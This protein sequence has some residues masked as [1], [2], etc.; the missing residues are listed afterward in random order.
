MDPVSD[1]PNATLYSLGSIN[2]DLQLCVDALPGEREMLLATRY[3]RLPGG[4]AANVAWF[5][6]RLGHRPVLLGRVGD[7]DFTRQ[8]LEPLAQ[9]GVDLRGV[10]RAHGA[11]GVA[12]V[13][14]PPDGKKRIVAAGEANQGFGEDDIDDVVRRVSK[15]PEGSVLAADYEVTPACV[16]RAIA[17][18][19]AR[20][21]RVVV[22]PSFPERVPHEDM[23]LIDVITPNEKEAR[24]LAGLSDASGSDTAVALAA[25]HVIAECGVRTVCVKL[26]GGGCLVLHEGRCWEQH[27]APINIVDTTGAGDAFTSAMA[28]SLLE[29]RPIA[30]AARRA[31]AASECAVAGYG[32]QPS[33]PSAA[34]LER[35]LGLSRRSEPCDPQN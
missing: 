17:A 19:K 27:A 32:A 3:A 20:G 2:A 30:E 10:Q 18:A 8:A 13:L 11:T 28:L 31:V 12:I 5:A 15:A 16:T 23:R 4:K 7:D 26:S 34:A 25:A 33:Y 14:V 22:D 6:A 21:L 24:A 1:H 9:A 29:G 35:R